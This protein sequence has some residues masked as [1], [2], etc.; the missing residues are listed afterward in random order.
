MTAGDGV[1]Q[2]GPNPA[3]DKSSRRWVAVGLGN[4]D[5]QPWL[6]G[7]VALRRRVDEKVDSRL[8]WWA[9]VRAFASARTT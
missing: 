6:T 8:P 5:E 3:L 4:G 7:G 1:C 9:G 2:G